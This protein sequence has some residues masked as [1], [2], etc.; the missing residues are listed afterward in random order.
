MTFGIF[1]GKVAVTDRDRLE[2]KIFLSV[3]RGKSARANIAGP[4]PSFWEICDR[5]PKFVI[6]DRD[7]RLGVDGR[8][9]SR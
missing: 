2:F 4:Y 6:E 7:R 5:G 8:A 1:S 3:S 9:H